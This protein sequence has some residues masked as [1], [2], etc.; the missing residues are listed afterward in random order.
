MK[1]RYFSEEMARLIVPRRDHM[2][3]P[4]AL[5]RSLVAKSRIDESGGYHSPNVADAVATLFGTEMTQLTGNSGGGVQALPSVTS[6]G[7][8]QR[9]FIARLA[10]ATQTNG[11]TIGMARIP[12]FASLLGIWLMTDTSLGS[13]TIS[14]GD[15][16]TAALYAAAQT[17]TTT[18]ALTIATGRAAATFGVPITSGYDSV[19]GNLVTANMPQTPGQGGGLYEDITMVV[20]VANLP[21]SGNLT[22]VFDYVID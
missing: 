9:Q 21:A 10:L 17:F 18:N 6:V 4:A 1:A 19:T 22:V 20:G 14:F 15:A 11:V 16:N 13:S 3:A 8:R 2:L 5:Y 7:G 12:L